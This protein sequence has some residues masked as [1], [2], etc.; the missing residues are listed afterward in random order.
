[1]KTLLLALVIAV[2]ACSSATGPE[3]RVP[4]TIDIE[5]DSTHAEQPDSVC[6]AYSFSA[7]Q[8]PTCVRWTHSPPGDS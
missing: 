6:A 5:I 2:A 7:G 8:A 4:T 3:E 1:M